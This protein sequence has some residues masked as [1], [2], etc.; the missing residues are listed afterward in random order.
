M[1][2]VREG[3]S[4]AERRAAYGCD[5]TYLTAKEAGFDSLRD[6]LCLDRDEQV[7]RPFHFALVDEADSILIDEARIPLILAG[8][9]AVSEEGPGPGRLAAIRS[10]P[11]PSRPGPLGPS[12]W[13]ARAGA[14]R[15]N[16]ASPQVTVTA[17]RC[18]ELFR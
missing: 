3:M 4:I 11:P 12:R 5:V 13:R 2:C 15:A 9:G 16:G 8:A 1:G 7:Q 6:G 10:P 18:M 14:S 17:T